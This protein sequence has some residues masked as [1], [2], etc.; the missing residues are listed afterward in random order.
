ER[1]KVCRSD[2]C[3]WAFYDSS[4]NRSGKWCDMAVCGNRTKV[5]NYRE[6]HG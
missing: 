4:R 2:T 5:A 3:R 1:L 6:R